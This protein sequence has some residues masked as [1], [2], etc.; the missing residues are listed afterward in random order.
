MGQS[1]DE[2]LADWFT[3]SGP[4][5]EGGYASDAASDSL[6]LL[7]SSAFLAALKGAA[8]RFHAFLPWFSASSQSRP[9]VGYNL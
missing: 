2:F 5:E 9:A 4:V 1:T 3:E 7:V 8:L 6:P